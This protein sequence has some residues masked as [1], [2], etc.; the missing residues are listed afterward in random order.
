MAHCDAVA[1]TYG[2]KFNRCAACFAHMAFYIAT[3][4]IQVNVTWNYF[5]ERITDSDKGFVYIFRRQACSSEQAPVRRA[6][7]SCLDL[8]AVHDVP[9][10]A[11]IMFFSIDALSLRRS[12]INDKTG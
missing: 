5:G 4:L 8:V 1:Y 3:Y 7:P 12:G 6:F 10:F 2:I 11:A 9:F